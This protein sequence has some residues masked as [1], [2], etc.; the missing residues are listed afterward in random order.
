MPEVWPSL[1]FADWRDTCATLHLW[2]QVVGK[3]RLVQSPWVNHSWHVP[4]YVTP[5][6]LTT[7]TIPH[8]TRAF[9]I[10]FDFIEHHLRIEVSDGG[11]RTLPLRPQPVAE[12]YAEVMAA[13]AELGVP[14]HVHTTP[15]EIPDAIP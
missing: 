5:R 3:V 11:A 9:A 6:G 2:S 1:A 12:F 8:G 14:V 15:N 7:S 10:T 13:L 4:L